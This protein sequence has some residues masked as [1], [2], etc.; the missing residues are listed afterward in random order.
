MKF[1]LTELESLFYNIEDIIDYVERSQIE[2]KKSKIFLANDGGITFNIPK[3]SI[4]HLI[5]IDTSYLTST[6]IFK[7][8][9]SFELLKE[10]V[11][12]PY[13][14]YT[15]VN[16]GVLKYDKIFSQYVLQK[17]ESF[18]ENIKINIYETQFV[19]KYNSTKSYQISNKSEKYDYIIV[20]KYLDGKIGVLGIVKNEYSYVPRSNRIYPNFESFKNEMQDIL[21]NQEITIMTGVNLYNKIDDYKKEFKIDLQGKKEKVS[22]LLYYKKLFNVS[23]DVSEDYIYNLGILGNE[24]IDRYKRNDN[25]DEIVESIINNEL[26]DPSAIYDSNLL[27]IVNAYNDCACKNEYSSDSTKKSYTEAIKDLNDFKILVNSLKE[28][29]TN[30]TNENDE[31]KF[32]NTEL[33]EKNKSNEETIS[34][35]IK[36]IKPRM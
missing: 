7:N 9:N 22:N 1:N 12:N 23:I 15:L 27:K 6:N 30:L 31:L 5:G 17:V 4:P 2:N 8:K 14:I 13:R 26:I 11:E 29:I 25:I 21:T 16:D 20:K 19:C 28:E 34:E 33:E 3:E 18:K 10:F 24:K 36:I 35:I 32:K